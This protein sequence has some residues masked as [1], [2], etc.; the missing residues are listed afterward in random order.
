M[1]AF[2]PTVAVVD[3][4]AIRH[5]IRVLAP[6]SAEVMAV[7]KADAYG[8][9]DVQV[10]RAAIEAGAM[11]LGVALVEEGIRLRKAGLTA[12]ILVLSEAPRGSETAA[13]E[14]GLTPTVY[15][16][17]GVDAL[18]G[19][20]A[21]VS[22]AVPVHV[23]VDTGM[24]RLGLAPGDVETLVKTLAD[25]GLMFEGLWTHFAKADEAHDTSVEN[26]LGVFNGVVD[27]LAASGLRPRYRH[28]ANSAA[29]L[30][31]PGAHLDLVRLGLAMY[32]LVPTGHRA[33]RAAT[34]K[35]AMSWK[36][37][38][39]LAKRVA[40][41]EGISYGWRY[42]LER[43][44][45]IATV[46]VGYADGYGRLLSNR[47]QVLIRGR[48]YRIAGTVTMD[49]VMVDCRADEIRPGDEVV[50]MGAQGDERVTADDVAGWMETINYEVVTRVSQR[51]PR[52]YVGAE[53]STGSSR[54]DPHPAAGRA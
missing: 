10:A 39:S 26:Q 29:L 15:T 32:G 20:A 47:G 4:G 19:A 12:P 44:S 45:T 38:V 11:W 21:A 50:L 7:V 37:Q 18:A 2:R 14:A 13:V 31:Y 22:S 1:I 36:S 30:G 24:H 8:H 49:H 27:V 54:D 46:P 34:L 35:P 3:L 48:R 52:V 33:G 17:D 43:A 41:G 9:G 25:R 6:P 51:V 5:N 42:R 23:K 40:A 53:E 28:A 16:H